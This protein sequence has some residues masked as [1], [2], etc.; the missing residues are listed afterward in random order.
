MLH[1][2]FAVILLIPSMV[3][4][5]A[6]VHELKLKL[7]EDEEVP[8]NNNRAFRRI[9][10]IESVFWLVAYSFGLRYDPIFVVFTMVV[11]DCCSRNYFISNINHT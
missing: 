5:M 2:L 11:D 10:K 3:H 7:T 4:L 1:Y 9:E 6:Y 8:V